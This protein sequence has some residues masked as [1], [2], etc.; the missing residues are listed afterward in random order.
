M[1]KAIT[2]CITD[3]EMG[4]LDGE[5]RGPP[6]IVLPDGVNVVYIEM[7]GTTYY[8]DDSTGEAIAEADYCSDYYAYLKR[9]GAKT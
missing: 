8:L 9:E 1:L 4:K 3:R 5:L 6:T 2:I 7:G